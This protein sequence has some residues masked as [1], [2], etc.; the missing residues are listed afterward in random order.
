VFKK[1]GSWL[2]NQQENYKKKLQIMKN[3]EIYNKWTEFIN[4]SI[5]KVYFISNKDNWIDILNKVKLYIDTTNK[6]PSS[7]DKIKEIKK[8]GQWIC[9]QKK[10]YN[11]KKYIMKNEEIYN[12]WT[13]FINDD[14]YKKY[15]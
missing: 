2:L 13:E 1:L 3:E 9:D 8:L 12:K 15:F 4:D 6:R 5:Y 14:N 7:G 11:N 10:N